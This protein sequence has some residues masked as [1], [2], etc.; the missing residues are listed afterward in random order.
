MDAV[1]NQMILIMVSQSQTH[2]DI[3]L[4][5]KFSSFNNKISKESIEYIRYKL[6]HFLYSIPKQTNFFKIFSTLCA[7]PLRINHLIKFKK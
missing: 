7:V 4:N 1:H 3:K 5:L 6:N 2:R